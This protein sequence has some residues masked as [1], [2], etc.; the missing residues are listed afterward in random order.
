MEV[1]EQVG[2]RLMAGGGKGSLHLGL[3]KHTITDYHDGF[4]ND[5]EFQ[6]ANF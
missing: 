3:A 2:I 1:A 5:R 6:N 4:Q